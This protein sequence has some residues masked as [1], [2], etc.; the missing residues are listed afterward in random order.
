MMELNPSLHSACGEL[1]QMR[2][3][4]VISG[5]FNILKH[6]KFTQ[7]SAQDNK[8]CYLWT[9]TQMVLNVWFFLFCFV[10]YT[11]QN[12]RWIDLVNNNDNGNDIYNDDH[13]NKMEWDFFFLACF[14]F[15]ISL[16]KVKLNYFLQSVI[17]FFFNAFKTSSVS[18]QERTYTQKSTILNALFSWWN[19]WFWLKL[20][21]ELMLDTKY[22]LHI[23]VRCN[24]TTLLINLSV[25]V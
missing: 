9:L 3:V 25:F 2:G 6:P 18:E 17:Y 19:V 14:H 7:T 4:N 11:N 21:K 8:Q 20:K 22:L 24:S 5:S 12:W 15:C 16:D 10:L 13:I 23:E 1:D